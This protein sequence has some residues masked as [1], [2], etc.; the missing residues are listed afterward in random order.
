LSDLTFLQ[1]SQLT[2]STDQIQFW[3]DNPNVGPYIQCLGKFWVSY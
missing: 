2:N 3:N 1:Q